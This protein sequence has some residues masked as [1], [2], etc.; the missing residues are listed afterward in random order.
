MFLQETVSLNRGG[1]RENR[2][3]LGWVAIEATR[4]DSSLWIL[5][6]DRGIRR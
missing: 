5:M 3:D 4:F 2:K 6:E 1:G